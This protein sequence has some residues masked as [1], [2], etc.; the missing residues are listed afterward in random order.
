MTKTEIWS[1]NSANVYSVILTAHNMSEIID[2]NG[3]SNSKISWVRNYWLKKTSSNWLKP[4][5]QHMSEILID[6]NRGG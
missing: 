3:I 4:V 2:F 5:F 1:I 6:E